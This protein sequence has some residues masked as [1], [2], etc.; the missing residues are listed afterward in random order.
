VTPTG[1]DVG[2]QP[3]GAGG[4][5]RNRNKERTE[6]LCVTASKFLRTSDSQGEVA[7]EG[8]CREGRGSAAA[9][10]F[11]IVR[12]GRKRVRGGEREK[13][14]EKNSPRKV[15]RTGRS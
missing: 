1:Q 3:E 8:Q 15:K 10:N 11:F 5:K 4:G 7:K 6:G 13:V 2:S 12:A 14:I 9:Q